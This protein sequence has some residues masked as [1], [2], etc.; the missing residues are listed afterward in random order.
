MIYPQIDIATQDASQQVFFAG[1][2]SWTKPSGASLIYFAI[3]G[4][5]AGGGGGYAAAGG[6]GGGGG[7]GGQLLFLWIPAIFVP[8]SLYLSVGMGG[9]GGNRGTPGSAGTAGDATSIILPQTGGTLYTCTGGN[10][11]GAGAAAAGGTAGTAPGAPVVNFF[12]SFG[13]VLFVNGDAGIAGGTTTGGAAPARTRNQGGGGGGGTGAGTLPLSPWILPTRSIAGPSPEL[14]G[15]P[16][17]GYAGPGGGLAVGGI[18]R[19]GENGTQGC[20][21]GGGGGAGTTSGGQGGKGGD[22]YII[23]ASM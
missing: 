12:T 4:A 10:P 14:R 7:S 15:S 21:G 19:D 13:S 11:G 16:L 8:D 18:T 23:I 2:H 22:G 9:A 6:G 20:G 17:N 1:K 5:G 3:S